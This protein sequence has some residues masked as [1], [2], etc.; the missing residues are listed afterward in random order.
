MKFLLVFLVLVASSFSSQ[1]CYYVKPDNYTSSCPGQPC[2]TLD[3][4]AAQGTEYFMMGATFLFLAGNHSI[5]STILLENVSN[6][7][8]EKENQSDN[9]SVLQKAQSSVIMCRNVTN[10][11]IQGVTFMLYTDTTESLAVLNVSESTE[12]LL[13]NLTFQGALKSHVSAAHFS[14]SEVLISSC[15]FEGNGRLDGGAIY[16]SE[17]SIITLDKNSFLKNQAQH[18]GGVNESALLL[19]LIER[20]FFT[21]N[22][23]VIKV[24]LFLFNF[25]IDIEND[26]QLQKTLLK[27]LKQA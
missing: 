24:A 16:T 12:V 3:Q 5:H 21:Y 9:I 10:L 22:S 1:V 18:F 8:F 2:L 19:K 4:Y 7:V 27:V 23:A 26:T 25:S 20:N 15:V 17:R 14:H 13:Q 11:T 6:I